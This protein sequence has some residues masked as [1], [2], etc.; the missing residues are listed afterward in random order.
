MGAAW[1]THASEWAAWART[2]MHDSY[3]PFHR[4]AF[5]ALVPPPGRLTVD[6]GCG[7]GRLSR[8]LKGLGHN[9]IGVDASPT[10]VEQAKEAD[11]S[12]E[13]LLAD[14]ARLPFVDGVADLA[15]AFMSL[16]DI[17][18]AAG[19]ISE[20]ARVLEPGGRFCLAIVHPF[21]S[22][23]EFD[24][25]D[26]DSPFV[27]SGSYLAEFRYA[28]DVQRGDMTM[29]FESAHRPLGWYFD[30]LE[31]SGLLVE[32]L[33]EVASPDKV[34]EAPRQR[35]WQRLPLFLHIRALRP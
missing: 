24:G 6:L 2:S 10:M 28:D 30:A 33:R 22:A 1:E 4:D 18:D 31:D 35:R 20:A 7:E 12:I 29:V 11:S 19:A 25:D 8:D 5:L 23:G 32:A 13:V 26:P 15:I 9:V 14:A 3:E 27:V 17:D 16:Q 34:I 21:A